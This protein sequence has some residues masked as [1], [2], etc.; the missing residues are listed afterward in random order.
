MFL[1]WVRVGSGNLHA[2][3][4]YDIYLTFCWYF[5]FLHVD[6]LQITTMVLGKSLSFHLLGTYTGSMPPPP[7]GLASPSRPFAQFTRWW[8]CLWGRLSD[9]YL[10]KL[11]TCA[12][13]RESSE[14]QESKELP[15]WFSVFYPCVPRET[16][17]IWHHAFSSLNWKPTKIDTLQGINISHLGKRKII[18][19]MPFLGDMLVPWRVDKICLLLF[20]FLSPGADSSLFF[21]GKMSSKIQQKKK[22]VNMTD[23]F[24]CC[25]CFYSP[26]HVIDLWCFH[27]VII[28]MIFSELSHN[29]EPIWAIPKSH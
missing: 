17:S 27:G 5:V 4:G 20:H 2:L 22:S 9:C 8:Q 15:L 23:I 13:L 19:K 24:T 6:L 3:E 12:K 1:G 18:F 25:C 28:L 26:C 29:H 16:H 11:R 14:C 7:A 21:L 10:Q